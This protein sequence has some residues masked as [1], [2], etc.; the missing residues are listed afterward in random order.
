M[1]I[2]YQGREF[3]DHK[4]LYQWLCQQKTWLPVN[5]L[6]YVYG[7]LL[8]GLPLLL[9]A[10]PTLLAERLTFRL[11][12]VLLAPALYAFSFVVLAG[13]MSAPFRAAIVPGKF[14]R[15]VTNL[16]Y[17]PRRLYALCWTSVFYFTPI[18]QLFMGIP[19]LRT[20]LLRGFGYRGHSDVSI[21][22][23]A[24]I[25]DIPLL[26]LGKG[27]YIANK[28]SVG[29]NVCMTD[30][31]VLVDK[32]TFEEGALLG[33]MSLLGPG[34][35]IGKCA[36]IGVAVDMGIRVRIGER[37]KIAPTTGVN[38]GAQ[39]GAGADIGSMSY[40]GLKAKIGEGLRLPS[41]TNIPDG[42]VVNT[43]EEMAAYFSSENQDLQ[44]KRQDLETQL[45]GRLMGGRPATGRTAPVTAMRG[46]RSASE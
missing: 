18:Y 27:V 24:W 16:V 34:S 7:V 28:A 23:D 35:N 41:G 8:F 31:S 21:A 42:A 37:A 10:L 44:S 29:T 26:S 36:E 2:S 19:A 46:N 32:V 40:I 12:A 6:L 20:V 38:H 17:G 1:P 25:R 33:H 22:P 9:A 15:D 13:A 45:A 5:G 3:N 4:E 39:I 30:G 14:P 43:Q 11:C